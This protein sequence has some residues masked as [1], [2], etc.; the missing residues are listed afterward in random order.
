MQR[1][2]Q[3]VTVACPRVREHAQHDTA[4]EFDEYSCQTNGSCHP[5]RPGWVGS[6]GYHAAV[7]GAASSADYQAGFALLFGCVA[8]AIVAST[9]FHE[10]CRNIAIGD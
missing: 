6:G 3:D 1:A 10:T 8:L 9:F 2:G 5:D 7:E 4:Y